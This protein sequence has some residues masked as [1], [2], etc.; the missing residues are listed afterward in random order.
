MA[1][2][3]RLAPSLPCASPI[4]QPFHSPTFPFAPVPA[5]A[6]HALSRTCDPA[7]TTPYFPPAA[8]A[9]MSSF[10]RA[11]RASS[12]SGFAG[13]HSIWLM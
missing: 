5:P 7:A 2:G 9:A 4:L 1:C 3:G 6:L 8:P 10:R 12:N 11:L 13:G